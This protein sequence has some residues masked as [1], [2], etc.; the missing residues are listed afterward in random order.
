MSI[1]YP[2]VTWELY[3]KFTSDLVTGFK[4]L[5]FKER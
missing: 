2:M 1:V 5:S 3:V 4:L